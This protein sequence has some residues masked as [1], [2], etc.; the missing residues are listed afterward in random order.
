MSAGL[1]IVIETE[2]RLIQEVA[3]DFKS[4]CRGDAVGG[5]GQTGL[6]A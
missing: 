3:G 4:P 2:S 1:G 5:I 6:E